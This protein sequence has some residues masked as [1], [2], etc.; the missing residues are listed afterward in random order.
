MEYQ[1]DDLLCFLF[2]FFRNKIY[3]Q[4]STQI[5]GIFRSVLG[6]KSSRPLVSW[7]V[8]FR[9]VKNILGAVKNW[10]STL[11]WYWW[12]HSNLLFLLF[13][14]FPILLPFLSFCSVYASQINFPSHPC[15]TT[16]LKSVSKNW[17]KQFSFLVSKL[18]KLPW[19]LFYALDYMSQFAST[20]NFS[21]P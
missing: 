4:I 7:V 8:C 3:L 10:T 15:S 1:L 12:V 11:L 21:R 5:K 16:E 2:L 17:V 20:S 19:S 9:R 6:F 14:C 18:V 13:F